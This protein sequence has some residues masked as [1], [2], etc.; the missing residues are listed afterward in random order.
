[1]RSFDELYNRV[2]F[3]T[4]LTTGRTGSDYLQACLDNVPGILT[5]SGHMNYYNNFCDNFFKLNKFQNTDP[6]KILELFIKTNMYLFTKD[7]RE[8]KNINLNYFHTFSIYFFKRK[9]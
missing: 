9:R 8:N 3:F 6:L 2:N 1:M 4:I 7:E 5:F